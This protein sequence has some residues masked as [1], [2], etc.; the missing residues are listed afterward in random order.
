MNMKKYNNKNELAN[1][2]QSYE[3][4]YNNKTIWLIISSRMNM[5]YIIIKRAG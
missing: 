3:N 2:K 1:N 5:K 4:I